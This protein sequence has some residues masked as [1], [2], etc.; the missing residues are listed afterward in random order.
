[1]T[2]PIQTFN[3]L[4][5]AYLRYFDSPFDLRFEELV[6]SRRALL[7]RDGVLY[8]HALVEPQPPY[9]GSGRDVRSAVASV[10]GGHAGWPPN[11]IA[12][13]ADFAELGLF[14][15][16]G[17]FPTELYT[18]QVEMLRT[19]SQRGEDAVIVTGTGLAKPKQYI[20]RYSPLS[21]GNLC[22]GLLC[23]HSLGMIDGRCLHRQALATAATILAFR[24]GSMSKV[25]AVLRSAHSCYILLMRLPR[26]K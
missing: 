15:L 24:S 7:D 25:G 2:D 6:Q 13:L 4:K 14:P 16:R 20:Y 9:A 12:D 1:M 21:C 3:S 23:L 17:G 18:H 8:R 5:D 10:L 19:S 26:I 11:A 22:D